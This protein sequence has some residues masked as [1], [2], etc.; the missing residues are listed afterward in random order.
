MMKFSILLRILIISII[1]IVGY[2]GFSV[3]YL[4][5]EPRIYENRKNQ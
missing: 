2:I 1:F 5:F 3:I 4:I